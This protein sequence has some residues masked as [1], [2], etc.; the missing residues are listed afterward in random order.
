MNPAAYEA[1]IA[2]LT[3]AATAMDESE[4]VRKGTAA[5][6]QL[7]KSEAHPEVVGVPNP[8]TPEEFMRFLH[9]AL[10]FQKNKDP[11]LN[12]QATKILLEASESD[13]G[14]LGEKQFADVIIGLRAASIVSLVMRVREQ[15]STPLHVDPVMNERLFKGFFAMMFLQSISQHIALE[16]S[17]SAFALSEELAQQNPTLN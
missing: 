12:A 3:L 17:M 8:T 16:S 6:L 5:L 10:T 14:L 13:G 7:V 11:E 15:S 1:G 9:S 4:K 2:V